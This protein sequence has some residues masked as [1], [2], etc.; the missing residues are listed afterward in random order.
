MRRRPLLAA[1][2]LLPAIARAQDNWPNRPIRIVVPFPPGGPNDLIA[3]LYAPELSRTL[4][5]PV[6]IEN[7]AGGAGV[8]GADNVVKSAPDGYSFAIVNGGSLVITPHVQS[9]PYQVADVGLVSEVAN[10]P[11]ALV[12]TPRLGVNTLPELLDYAK[13]HPGSLNI[14]T[15]GQGGISHLAAVLFETETRAGITVVPYRGAAPAVTDLLAGQIQLL[16]ADLPPVLAQVKGGTLKA[17][18][19]AARQ[20]SPALPDLRTTVEYGFPRVLAENWY[21]MIGPRNLPPAILSRMSDAVKAASQSAPVRDGL[22][23][24]GAMPSWTSVED[25][26]KRVRED[27]AVWA[28]VARGANIRTD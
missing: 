10:V 9:M 3:R 16:F 22:V 23:S 12:A 20:R 19:L 6:V 7:R 24:Q 25:F 14:G 26:A 15:A 21:C 11:E 27:S 18:A 28:E 17:L 8:V 1:G 4:G 13:A 2:L 5:T